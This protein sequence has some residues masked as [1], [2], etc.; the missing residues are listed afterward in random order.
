MFNIQNLHKYKFPRKVFL[1]VFS[2]T[3]V[4]AVY[5]CNGV[6]AFNGIDSINLW[7][8][9]LGPTQKILFKCLLGIKLLSDITFQ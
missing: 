5:Q 4:A 8:K 9:I 2:F 7:L 1:G 6:E 3:P